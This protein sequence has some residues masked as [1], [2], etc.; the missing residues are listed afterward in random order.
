MQQAESHQMFYDLFMA[1][2]AL[3]GMSQPFV[4]HVLL[5]VDSL[6]SAKNSLDSEWHLELQV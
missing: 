6:K 5:A 1:L 4:Q 3:P 2:N